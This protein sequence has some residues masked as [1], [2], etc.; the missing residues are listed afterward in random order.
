MNYGTI[1]DTDQS[2]QITTRLEINVIDYFCTFEYLLSYIGVE[3]PKNTSTCY[4]PFHDNTHTKAAKFYKEEHNEHVFC[5]AEGKQ[6]KPHHLLTKEI[7]PFSINHVFSAI[8]SQLSEEEKGIFS[9][10]LKEYK[11]GRDFSQYY[12]SYKK[13]KLKYFDLLSILKNP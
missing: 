6:Y 5:F 11:V 1:M 8:W 10:D 9:E 7:V 12:N 13:C 4:C 3:F 2:K